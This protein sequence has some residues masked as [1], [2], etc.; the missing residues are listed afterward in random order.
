MVREKKTTANFS[1]ELSYVELFWCPMFASEFNACTGW[2]GIPWKTTVDQI[3][4]MSQL[5]ENWQFRFA[6]LD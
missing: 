1:Y 3:H 6:R 4:D 2:G 5:K